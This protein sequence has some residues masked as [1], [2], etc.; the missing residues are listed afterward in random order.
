VSMK[1][2]VSTCRSGARRRIGRY[3]RVLGRRR[4]F[5]RI[6][7]RRLDRPAWPTKRVQATFALLLD[8]SLDVLFTPTLPALHPVAQVAVPARHLPMTLVSPRRE[9]IAENRGI[10]SVLVRDLSARCGLVLA[11]PLG[12]APHASRKGRALLLLAQSTSLVGAGSSNP[13]LGQ[14]PFQPPATTPLAVRVSHP[15]CV[16]SAPKRAE[17]AASPRRHIKIRARP[18]LDG[19]R[20]VRSVDQ[21]STGRTTDPRC[22]NVMDPDGVAVVLTRDRPVP[23]NRIRRTR[24]R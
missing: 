10:W 20:L 19:E 14:G 11:D 9:F 4:T 21:V 3:A 23:H 7:T 16:G 17:R 1:A 22:V 18:V 5:D 8:K 2:V 12:R 15:V 6:D 13:Q 24:P